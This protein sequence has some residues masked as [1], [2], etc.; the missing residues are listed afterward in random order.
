MKTLSYL[1]I[2]T[3][4]CLNIPSQGQIDGQVSGLTEIVVDSNGLV[5][6]KEMSQSFKDEFNSRMSTTLKQKGESNYK[7]IIKERELNNL[8]N[9]LLNQMSIS[10][11]SA[12]IY[13][14]FLDNQNYPL[15]DAL[16]ELMNVDGVIWQR[17]YG[18]HEY[19]LAPTVE[20][21]EEFISE[22]TVYDALVGKKRLSQMEMIRVQVTN[23]VR[24]LVR[25]MHINIPSYISNNVLLWLPQH[26]LSNFDQ[27]MISYDV[28]EYKHGDF[29]DEIIGK[30]SRQNNIQSTIWSEGFEGSMS[31]YTITGSPGWA[32]K[33]CQSYE[34]SWSLYNNSASSDC[35][36]YPNNMNTS[37]HKTTGINVSNYTNVV[38]TFR[39]K[40]KTEDSFD[41][42][43][44]FY[45]STGTS[46]TLGNSYSGTSSGWPSSWGLYT[47]NLNGFS[48]YYW[49][50]QFVSDGSVTDVGCFIDDMKITG[51]PG[52]LPNLTLNQAS[53]SISYNNTTL[54]SSL[55][56]VNDG[57]A[58]TGASF[59]VDHF[60]STESNL[61]DP[62]GSRLLNWNHVTTNISAGSGVTLPFSSDLALSNPPLNPGTYYYWFYIDSEEQIS[63]SNEDDNKW[64]WTTPI[65]WVS[66]ELCVTP[67]SRSVTSGSGSTTFTVQNCGSGTM[68]WSAT[69]NATWLSLSPA[70]GSLNA[71]QTTTVTATYTANTGTSQRTG[72][73]TVTASG[74]TGSPKTV[75][76]TQQGVTPPAEL[77]VT[78]TSRNVTSG[79][80]STT[81]TVQN[82][83]SGTMSWSATDNATWLSLSPASGSLN[84]GQTTTVTA[85]YTANTGTSQRTGTVTVTASG[86]TGSPKTVTITQQGVTPP[87]EL[88]V[89][90]TSR[91]VTSGSGSTT[92]TVQNCGSGTMS[93]S[94]SS[95]ATW[96]PLSPASGSL[97]AGQTIAV[98]VQ[99][100]ANTGTSPRTATVTVTAP[101]ATGSPK[102]VTITQEGT[103]GPQGSLCIYPREQNTS[104]SVGTTIPLE[105]RVDGIPS[106][107]NFYGVSFHLEWNK[108]EYI[109]Y[110]SYSNGAVLGSNPIVLVQPFNNRI[111][112]GATRTSG[113]STS[114]GVVIVCT[115]KVKSQPPQQENITLTLTNITATQSDGSSLNLETCGTSIINFSSCIEV[116]PGDANNDGVVNVSDL[117]RIGLHYNKTGP[118]RNSDSPN[119]WVAQCVSS[120]WNPEAAAYADC[121]GNG[122]VNAGDVLAIGLNYGR[123]HGT[124]AKVSTKEETDSK[125]WMQVYDKHNLP[126]TLKSLNVGEEFY[127]SI[128]GSSLNKTAGLAFSLE[129]EGGILELV[130]GELQVGKIFDEDALIIAHQIIE[131]N[132]IEIGLSNKNGNKISKEGEIVRVKLKLKTKDNLKVYIKEMIQMNT[133]GEYM[134][135][136]MDTD[137]LESQL[138]GNKEIEEYTLSNYPNP[139]NPMTKIEFSIPEQSRVDMKIYN[140]LGEEVAELIGGRELEGG[141][142]EVE[143]DASNLPSGIYIYSL[144]TNN[145]TI[146]K[147]MLLI[148]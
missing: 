135:S 73:V 92:F 43:N 120:G 85:T 8:D 130:E 109:E 116:W 122:L 70:S 132:K 62:N 129:F 124:M 97:S 16:E 1:F 77:C 101:G 48:T 39:M 125:V 99:Y 36:Q 53:T 64:R 33:N 72:T 98:T 79:S 52:G 14:E 25:E 138:S 141:K 15:V 42:T 50:F 6:F 32:D 66:T 104:G 11:N 139:F 108:P 75:T 121:N 45:S 131:E 28:V 10:Q 71:G 63:E 49:R 102:T 93:W 37:I 117:L 24:A 20:N 95:N 12:Q 59:Y 88:C 114:G 47:V 146:V 142:Y 107:A 30:G 134:V 82:C 145:N 13:S 2:L 7:R 106:S 81:F 61:W 65:P 3:F 83:G 94:A 119:N 60:I 74:A 126:K 5:S 26:Y 86:A 137:N 123:T 148:K 136:V 147:K 17:W 96:L 54:S 91:N 41:G 29:D 4:F 34:G 55:R 57:N 144:R 111:E 18:Q 35:S 127:L 40:Y 69:D 113:S 44:R 76:I 118:A 80:G 87:A 110:D 84:A 105:I 89:T 103:G 9:I 133:D 27:A 23:E 19:F 128:Q 21:V 115:L 31:P 51:D 46:W 100:T 140:V 38:M 22:I 90:P 58:S 143:W 67:T 56:V 78:P 112:V 68:S